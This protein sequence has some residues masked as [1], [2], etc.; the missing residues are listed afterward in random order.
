MPT[1]S[2]FVAEHEK[3]AANLAPVCVSRQLLSEGAYR[4]LALA[5]QAGDHV[6]AGLTFEPEEGY[7]DEEERGTGAG[8]KPKQEGGVNDGAAMGEGV[9][10]AGV[11]E[12]DGGDNSHGDGINNTPP[13]LATGESGGGGGDGSPDGAEE[14]DDLYGDLY[15]GLDDDGGGGTDMDGGVRN[16][17]GGGGGQDGAGGD[18]GGVGGEGQGAGGLN[19]SGAVE[20]GGGDGMAEEVSTR[21]VMN[22]LKVREAG[23]SY[24]PPLAVCRDLRGHVKTFVV[25]DSVLLSSCTGGCGGVAHT[26]ELFAVPLKF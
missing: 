19:G 15:G 6:E 3:K 22:T 17:G 24:L 25:P 1:Q 5:R 23:L 8:V 18:G 21:A 26:H 9:T 12:M 11:A 13:K 2:C 7:D 14:E 20:A 4:S 10:P 16:G